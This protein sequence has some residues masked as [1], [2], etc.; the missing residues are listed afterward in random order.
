MSW[1]SSWPNWNRAGVMKRLDRNNQRAHATRTVG[2]VG[3]II[4]GR[5]ELRAVLA[6]LEALL[7][8]GHAGEGNI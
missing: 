8:G 6:G 4:R 3:A 5:V 1:N 7:H 2:R